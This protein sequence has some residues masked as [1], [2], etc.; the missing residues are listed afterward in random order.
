MFIDVK[1]LKSL[2]KE[3][4]KASLHVAQTEERIYISGGYW[5][6]DM[7]KTVMPKQVMAQLIEL[8][9][10]VPEIGERKRY[11]KLKSEDAQEPEY[12]RMEVEENIATDETPELTKIIL[13]DA[14]GTANRL[15]WSVGGIYIVNNAF[16][17]ASQGERD[18]KEET[19]TEMFIT[20]DHG[21]LW[22]TNLARMKCAIK[23]DTSHERLLGEL[24]M[25]DLTEDE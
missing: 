5:E 18:K 23:T 17:T 1:V 15:L 16:V 2:M 20:R 9:G 6:V 7:D 13:L 24:E 22:K 11:Y 21:V 14:F 8:A 10:E 19:A 25:L 4:Y 12:G 3:A